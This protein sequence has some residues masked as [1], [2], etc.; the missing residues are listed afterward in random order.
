M[1]SQIKREEIQKRL[2]IIKNSYKKEMGD[3]VSLANKLGWKTSQLEEHPELLLFVF[4]EYLDI[5]K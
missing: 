4:Y 1:K 5:I 2:L 3:I